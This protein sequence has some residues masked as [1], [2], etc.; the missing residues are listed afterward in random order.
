[1]MRTLCFFGV[2]MLIL[3]SCKDKTEEVELRSLV[4]GKD[5]VEMTG[6]RGKV[7]DVVVAQYRELELKRNTAFVESLNELVANGFE[8]Q[9]ERFEDE[10]LGFWAGYGNMFGYL[11]RSKEKWE[12]KLRL[13][14]DKYF[15]TLEIEQE[16]NEL[17]ME[18]VAYVKQLRERFTRTKNMEISEPLITLPQQD[19]YLGDLRSHSGTN[20]L[21]EVGTNI[22]EWLLRIC[23]VWIIGLVCVV[24]PPPIGLIISI[25]TTVLSIIG[26]IIVIG[27]NDNKLIN[28][29][30]EQQEVTLTGDCEEILNKLNKETIHFY[31]KVK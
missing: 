13:E 28:S 8:K 4:Y 17:Y 19:I 16:A 9:L 20:V 24:I 27:M 30:R 7:G 15:S 11:F 6:S 29:I 1:M 23:I 25:A 22:A 18:H 26:S 12:D 10:E 2:W 31:E 21:I 14:S 5:S 3:A